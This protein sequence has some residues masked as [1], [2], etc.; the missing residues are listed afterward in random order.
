MKLTK[1]DIEKIAGWLNEYWQGE[2]I[3]PICHSNNWT[4]SDEIYE[5]RAFHGGRLV[6]GGPVF[7]AVGIICT[8]CGHTLFFNAIKLDLV[9]PAPPK[10]KESSTN[11]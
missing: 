4:I 8:V 5:F 7:P 10:K 3:C 6:V 1:P 9:K 11:E 2:K